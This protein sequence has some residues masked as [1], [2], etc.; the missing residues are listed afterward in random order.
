MIR[1]TYIIFC[2]LLSAFISASSFTNIAGL[3]FLPI[4]LYFIVAI[5]IKTDGKRNW[6]AYYG[7]ILTATLTVISITSW[8]ALLFA[9]LALH[10]LLEILPKAKKIFPLP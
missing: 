3:A 8:G 10:F 5:F 6:F 9:P 4:T 1:R 2:A 7:F